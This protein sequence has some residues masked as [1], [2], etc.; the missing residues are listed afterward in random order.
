MTETAAHADPDFRALDPATLRCIERGILGAVAYDEHLTD[1]QQ[2]LLRAVGRGVLGVEVDLTRSDPMPENALAAALQYEDPRVRRRVVQLMIMLELILHPLPQEVSE[3][4]DRYA[5]ALG[6][7]D[8]MLVV[9]RDYAHGS[10]GLA[11]ADFARNG[12][13][14]DWDHHGDVESKMHVH[15]RLV[16]P[17]AAAEHDPELLQTWRNLE[18]CPPGSLGAA[19]WSYYLGHGFVFPGSEGSVSPTLAQHDWIHVLADY[20]TVVDSE[21]E[22]FGFISAAIPDPKGFSWLAAVLG[23]FETGTIKE[24]AGG[25]LQSDPGHL[26]KPGMAERLADALRRGRICNRDVVYGVDLLRAGGSAAAGSSRPPQRRAQIYGGDRGRIGGGDRPAGVH[27]VPKG[28]RRP[29]PSTTS[30][31]PRGPGSLRCLP[32]TSDARGGCGRRG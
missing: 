21:L 24:G 29:F 23:L 30:R 17:F 16:A 19:M 13:F 6:V 32:T 7:D 2:A 14:S 22:V 9:A 31:R 8:G 3:Q 5:A 4:V 25:V 20:A 18:K 1:V 26:R 11:L 12:Y 27:P 10:Y 28:S 15:E